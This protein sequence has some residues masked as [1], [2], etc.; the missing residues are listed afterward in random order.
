[1]DLSL[2]SNKNEK[3]TK[4]KN[5]K[6]SSMNQAIL[7][8]IVKDTIPKKNG[9]NKKRPMSSA[10]DSIETIRTEDRNISFHSNRINDFESTVASKY[11]KTNG[12]VIHTAANGKLE[13]VKTMRKVDTKLN[14]FHNNIP[15]NTFSA[16]N[17]YKNSQIKPNNSTSYLEKLKTDLISKSSLKSESTIPDKPNN[18][19]IDYK[20]LLEELM[21]A[22]HKNSK[23]ENEMKV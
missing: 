3:I 9:M 7:S 19:Q 5:G 18:K 2:D 14:T 4:K 13:S 21:E 1:M 16:E 20:R 23:L 11:K 22:K 17:S 6:T 15:K 8:R 12:K 10:Q